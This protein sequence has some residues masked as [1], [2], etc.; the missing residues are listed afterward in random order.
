[1]GSPSNERVQVRLLDA[2]VHVDAV[3]DFVLQL[4]KNVVRHFDV[5]CAESVF[6]GPCLAADLDSG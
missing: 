3:Q 6:V 1:M 5:D 4:F 2:E